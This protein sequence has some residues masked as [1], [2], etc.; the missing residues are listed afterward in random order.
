[1]YKKNGSYRPIYHEEFSKRVYATALGLCSLNLSKG[2]R[3]SVLSANSL[4]WAIADMSILLAG[5]INV[6]IYATLPP[7]QIEYILNDAEARAIFVSNRPQLDKIMQ[8]KSNLPMLAAVIT[9]EESTSGDAIT[10]DDLMNRAKQ[11]AR[12]PSV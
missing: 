6:P 10:L 1:M 9:F 11:T 2:D 4:E 7:H 5:C 8:I 3:I 12:P